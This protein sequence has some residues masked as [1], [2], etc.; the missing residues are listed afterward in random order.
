[1]M[2]ALMISNDLAYNI[3]NELKISDPIIAE[4]IFAEI[5]ASNSEFNIGEITIGESTL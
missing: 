1:M 5:C 4:T 2:F 3:I